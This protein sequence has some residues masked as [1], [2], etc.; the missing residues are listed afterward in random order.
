MNIRKLPSKAE[1]SG[2][3][4][5]RGLH[6]AKRYYVGAL[7]VLLCLVTLVLPSPYVIQ[8]AGPTQDV[9]GEAGG[10]PVIAVSGVPS[11]G[12]KGKLLLVTVNA[13]GVPGYPA[14]TA[15]TLLAWIDPHRQVM[16]SEAIFPVG[17]NAKQYKRESDKQMSGSQ[18][19]A[20]AAALSYAKAHHIDTRG[21]SVKLHV[22][23]IGGPSAGMMYALGILSKLTEADETGGMTIAGTGTMNGSGSVGAIGGIRLKMLGA[24]RDGAAWFLAPA[25]NC[26]EVVGHVPSGLRDVR[27]S[28]LSEAY[29]ALNAIGRGKGDALPHCTVTKA[30]HTG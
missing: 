11:H 10:K 28:T 6:R 20:T 9:L 16:P 26:N 17:Q 12:S 23:K 14:L 18:D 2:G 25:A 19:S 3:R 21:V 7:C 27:V 1:K 30:A 15:E 8:S 5:G 4:A 22:D 24:R 13:E 29:D